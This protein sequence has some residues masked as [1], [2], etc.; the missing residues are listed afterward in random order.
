[1]S[2]TASSRAI[3]LK[4]GLPY[5]R[6]KQCPKCYGHKKRTK[7]KWCAHCYD[8]RD[9]DWQLKRD[10]CDDTRAHIRA[11]DRGRYHAKRAKVET[12]LDMYLRALGTNQTSNPRKEKTMGRECSKKAAARKAGRKTYSTGLYCGQCETD[13]RYVATGNCVQC[14]KRLAE[15]YAKSPAGQANNRER[16]AR[17][18]ARQ[19]AKKNAL[20]DDI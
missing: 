4:K 18:R 7:D 3:A 8:L 16:Q 5:Y 20:F 10:W 11:L 12:A 14:A 15:R 13:R 17:Y 1:M 19:A 9:L 6:G 2:N